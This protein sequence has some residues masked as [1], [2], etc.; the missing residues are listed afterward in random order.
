VRFG[1]LM[2]PRSKCERFAKE[3]VDLFFKKRKQWIYTTFLAKGVVKDFS[4]AMFFRDE[5]MNC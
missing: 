5:H 4:L 3:V 2:D 1:N